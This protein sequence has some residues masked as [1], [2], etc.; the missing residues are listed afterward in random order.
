MDLGLS[1]KRVLITGA[2]KG[3]GRAIAEGLAEEGCS[4]HL[5]SRTEADLVQARDEINEKYGVQSKLSGDPRVRLSEGE[6]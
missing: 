5:A 2:S 1:G 4:L 6:P 3:I